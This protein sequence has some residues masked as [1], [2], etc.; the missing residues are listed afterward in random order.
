MGFLSSITGGG[1]GK[2]TS[3]SGYGAA[4]KFLQKQLQSQVANT[5]AFVDPSNPDNIARF[6]PI[7]QTADETRA[8]DLIRQGFSPT[9][10]S[11]SSDL[12]M[13]SN[14]YTDSIISEINRQSQGANSVLQQNVSGAGQLNSNRSILGANDIDL[15]RTNQIGSFLGDQYNRNLN[16]AL[17]TLPALRAADAT[18]LAG[19]GADQRSLAFQ[20][21]QAPVVATQ[22]QAGLN[23]QFPASTIQ[24]QKSGGGSL[25]GNVGG[26][27]SGISSLGGSGGFLSGASGIGSLFGAGSAAA[28]AYPLQGAASALLAA[29]DRSLKENI[30]AVGQENGHNIYEFNYIGDDKKFIGVMADEVKSID[31]Q[32]VHHINGYDAVNYS[33]I[34]VKF[35][36]A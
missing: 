25:L 28:S 27:L 18:G 17:T 21:A 11:L 36:A 16:Y 12:S 26:L 3:K 33:K 14:P 19:I 20:Q 35:R 7:D 6:T 13:L 2:S 5:A 30:K 4:P 9:A 23:A 32:A 8:Y 22:T 24:T 29:S 15:A 34:G 1:G 31:P 10:D